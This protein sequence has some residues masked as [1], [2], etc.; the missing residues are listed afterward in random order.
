MK[1]KKGK[2][3]P[4]TSVLSRKGR[5]GTKRTAFPLSLTLARGRVPFPV[6]VAIAKSMMDTGP[7][8]IKSV[9]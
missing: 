8:P 7:A 2:D 6:L 1:N 5:G 9:D 3:F 4:L